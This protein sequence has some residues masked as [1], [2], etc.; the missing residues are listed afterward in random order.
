MMVLALLV[1]QNASSALLM[2]YSRGVLQ[3]PY[4]PTSAV[5][6]SECCKLTVCT[7][8]IMMGFGDSGL[9][10][11][12]KYSSIQ[13]KLWYLIRH[14]GYSWVPAACYF[15][16]N[17]LYYIA[18]GNLGTLQQ[19]KILSAA[20]CSVFI[21]GR[22]LEWRQWRALLLLIFGGV[23]MEYHS[24]ELHDSDSLQNSNDPYKGTMAMMA[25][26]TISGFAGV[27]TEVL[28]KN[29][30][31][32]CGQNRKM[33][34]S[35][36]VSPS[37]TAPTVAL[38]IWDRNIQLAFWSIIFGA[39]TLFM[40]TDDVE[41]EHGLRGVDGVDGYGSGGI[42]YGWSHITMLLVVLWTMGGL[43]VAMTIKFTDVIVKGFASAM[44]LIVICIGGNVVLGDTL[45]L[46]FLVGAGVTII[47]TFNYN[48]KGD[49]KESG[50]GGGGGK[51][52]EMEPLIVSDKK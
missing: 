31:F 5:L 40:T 36:D 14:S 13:S 3:E 34:K 23:L 24:F 22:R 26:V 41:G 8:L 51:K 44:S 7:I 20:L 12:P 11:D 21:L 32:V 50:G 9:S 27:I 35:E 29:K 17:S 46:I 2:R 28:L 37:S 45:D 38:S 49:R 19:M 52:M 47:S 33:T 39:V 43:L 1:A 4:N 15:A 42:F 25:I 30:P 16:Q 18:S 6:M 48:D 10:R